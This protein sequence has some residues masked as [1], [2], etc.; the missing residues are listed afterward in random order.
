MNEKLIQ[1]LHLRNVA[2]H[3][4]VYIPYS[5]DSF[6]I[7]IL[8]SLMYKKE[9]HKSCCMYNLIAAI[10]RNCACTAQLEY[11][12]EAPTS[13]ISIAAIL[14]KITETVIIHKTTD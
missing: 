1:K 6:T 5:C 11:I 10:F 7:E 3:R 4:I 14:Q 13:I 2:P 9:I 12:E 8:I